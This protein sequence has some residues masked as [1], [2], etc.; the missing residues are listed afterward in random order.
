MQGL[1]FLFQA[2]DLLRSTAID[3]LPK[4]VTWTMSHLPQSV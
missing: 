1:P 3:P 2:V 4:L